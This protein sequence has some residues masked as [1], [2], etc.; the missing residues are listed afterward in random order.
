MSLTSFLAQ[1]YVRNVFKAAF[2]K[3]EARLA[4][5]SDEPIPSEGKPQLVGTAFD[6]LA[7]FAIE[8]AHPEVP[9][10]QRPWVAEA[11]VRKMKRPAAGIPRGDLRAAEGL[12]RE[13]RSLQMDYAMGGDLTD[14]L[15]QGCLDLAKLDTFFR[16]GYAP[17]RFGGDNP[18]LVE[19]LRRLLDRA[20][21][22][23]AHPCREIHLNPVFGAW[24]S[25][26]GGADADVIYDHE[27]T[28]IKTVT[29]RK[30]RLDDWLQLMGYALLSDLAVEDGGEGP[31][32]DAVALY[33]SRFGAWWS[34][35]ISPLKGSEA[36]MSMK[37]FLREQLAPDMP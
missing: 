25:Y 16:S 10:N 31:A 37:E 21:E 23:I 14:E 8:H 27:L 26:V 5:I 2:P 13:V 11:A 24:S 33:Y 30:V 1:P 17:A 32:V 22:F 19:E 7:R 28:D 34:V 20:D 35:D 6:Y 4:D 9:V 3:P 36:W 12:I 15:V 18:A 29:E